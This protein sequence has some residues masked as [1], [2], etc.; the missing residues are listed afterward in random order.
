MLKNNQTGRVMRFLSF[1][2][3][4]SMMSKP[5]SKTFLIPRQSNFFEDQYGSSICTTIRCCILAQT[6]QFH[7]ADWIKS[8]DF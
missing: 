6:V 4:S 3:A 1:K 2:I 5:F 8:Y 7:R